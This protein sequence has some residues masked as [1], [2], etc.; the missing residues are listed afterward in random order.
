[1]YGVICCNYSRRGGTSPWCAHLTGVLPS[2]GKYGRFVRQFVKGVYDYTYTSEYG[3]R[4]SVVVYFNVQPGVYQV[5]DD[6]HSAH[7]RHYFARVDENGD[8]AE[9]NEDEVVQCLKNEA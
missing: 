4:R 7:G 6:T 8:V 2:S 9:I 5:Y 1:M 3:G